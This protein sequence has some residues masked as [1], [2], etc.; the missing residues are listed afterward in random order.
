MAQ[1]RSEFGIAASLWEGNLFEILA[2][3]T[4]ARMGVLIKILTKAVLHSLKNGHG[5]VD[6]AILSN[7]ANRYGKRY[8]PLEA[9]NKPK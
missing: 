9:R 8:I 2:A 3:S 6:E 5:K 1:N 7:I 4:Q